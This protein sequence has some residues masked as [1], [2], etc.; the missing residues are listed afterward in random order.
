MKKQRLFLKTTTILGCM[1]FSLFL[2]G[3]DKEPTVN[4]ICDES[5]DYCTTQGTLTFNIYG[6][7][8]SILEY[9]KA[10]QREKEIVKEECYQKHCANKL[11]ESYD[12]W[13]MCVV[14][15]CSDE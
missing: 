1:V 7:M 11:W 13:F 6:H 10:N 8:P 15:S 12:H 2:V 5:N 3:C 9:Q 4:K 14:H